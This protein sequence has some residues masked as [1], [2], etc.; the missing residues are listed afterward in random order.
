MQHTIFGEIVYESDEEAWLGT[1]PLPVFAEY[2]RL[3]PDD[4]RLMEPAPE[5]ERGA[6]AFIVQDPDCNGPTEPQANAFR[7]LL[8]READVCRAV[9]TELVNG[10]GMHGGIIHWL[11]ERRESRFWGWLAWLVGPEYKTPED[12]K[13]AAR[14]I[15]F[16]VSRQSNGAYAYIAF[17][18]QTVFGIEI[19]H[20][21]SVVFHPDSGT[22]GGDASA[23][24]DLG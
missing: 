5:F 3:A 7:Y 17:Y 16:E 11:N 12:L 23:I 18:F 10:I 19:E 15:N 14:C 13:Q 4:H 22:F 24:H 8:D 2:G 6:F 20:G 9:M 21:L 1:C